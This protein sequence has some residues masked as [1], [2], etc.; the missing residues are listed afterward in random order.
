MSAVHGLPD[1]DFGFTPAT[2]TLAIRRL[3]L[4]VGDD[5]AVTAAWLD[6]TDW[7]LKPLRQTYRRTGPQTYAYASPD[8]GYQTTLTCNDFGVVTDYPGLW[9]AVEA[10]GR[11]P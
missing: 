3:A 6:P 2:N 9:Q 8:T 11:T 1:L 5:A 10:A 7:A 4:A